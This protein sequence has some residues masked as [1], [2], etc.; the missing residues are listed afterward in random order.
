MQRHEQ[1][2]SSPPRSSVRPL[3]IALVEV[4]FGPITWPSIG[5]SLLKARLRRDGHEASVLYLSHGFLDALGGPSEATVGLYHQI[6]DAFDIHLGE[7]IFGPY[8]HPQADWAELDAAFLGEASREPAFAGLLD[9]ACRAREAAGPYLLHVFSH[10]PWHDFDVIGFANSY[11]QLNASV[12]LARLLKRRFPDK[13]LI[14]G[15]CGC[16]DEMG[17]GLLAELDLFDA[18][19]LGEADSII[20]PLVEAMAFR[21]HGALSRI[22][23]IAFRK[24]GAVHEGPP[25]GRVTD[26]DELPYPDY[27]DYFRFRPA[28]LERLMPFYIPVEA[29]RGCWWGAK[30]HCTFCGLNPDRMAYFAKTPDRFLAEVD[31][32]RRMY[33]PSRFMAVDNIMPRPYYAKVLPRLPEASGGAE[34]FFEVKANFR[35]EEMAAFRKANVRQVQPGI[36]SLRSGI[37]RTMRKG[38]TGPANIHTLRMAEEM[39]LRA[40]WSILYGFVGER[41]EDYRIVAELA[42]RLFHL[43]PPLGAVQAEIERF[44][45]MYRDPA[46]Q[47]LTNLRPSHWYRY[48][49]PFGDASLA[50]IAYRFDGD[51]VGRPEGLSR[52]IAGLLEPVVAAWKDA[53]ARGQARLFQHLP[54]GRAVRV[55]RHAD[56]VVTDYVLRG[57]AVR[58]HAD[59][60]RPC[61]IASAVPDLDR[62]P[63]YEPYLDE[64]YLRAAR[65]VAGRRGGTVLIDTQTEEEA[66]R[67]L[68]LHGLVIEEDGTAVAIAC[69]PPPEEEGAA[70]E[71]SEENAYGL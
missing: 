24:G 4:P 16:S 53:Y 15:G 60:R 64:D 71:K 27:E 40:H 1:A 51:F 10:V 3:R 61:R 55:T 31:H 57:A 21:D 26:V 48:S 37:L 22:P 41:I 35:Q 66:Y 50:R 68:L 11:S 54:D 69:G 67:A 8:A 62:Q 70:E 38:I 47:G 18:V 9:A 42:R 2:D 30:N 44:A 29:S 25:K 63:G 46:G 52:D 56:N 58:L 5:T 36:E 43:R 49:Y 39:G 17:K 33:R 34:F 20:T 65:A 14:M 32:F 23:G 59:L 12:A 45:P 6:T 13:P 7:W 19:A 28:G